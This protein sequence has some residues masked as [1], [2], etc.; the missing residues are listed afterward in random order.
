MPFCMAEGH[1]GPLDAQRPGPFVWGGGVFSAPSGPFSHALFFLPSGPDA[2]CEERERSDELREW[3]REFPGTPR[4]LRLLDPVFGLDFWCDLGG[5][6]VRFFSRNFSGHCPPSLCVFQ[7]SACLRFFLSEGFSQRA[8]EWESG[9]FGEDLWDQKPPFASRKRRKK[10]SHFLSLVFYT[11][12][13]VKDCF[14]EG[15]GA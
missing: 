5:N 13:F 7:S 6:A 15:F 8:L 11:C 10:S 12:A 3:L 9:V 2:Q 14:G 4:T 1:R